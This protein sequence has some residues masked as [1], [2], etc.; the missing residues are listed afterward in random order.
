VS[1]GDGDLSWTASTNRHINHFDVRYSP[2][3]VYKTADETT[4]GSVPKTQLTFSTNV[5]LGAPGATGLY[6][7][8][9]VLTTLNERGSNTMGVFIG[10]AFDL[11]LAAEEQERFDHWAHRGISYFT[12]EAPGDFPYAR[13]K[14]IRD[15]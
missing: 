5:G 6:K 11:S 4:I 2:G 8:Y 12:L 14:T 7:V 13:T 1:T 10:V 9:A 15:R 3:P